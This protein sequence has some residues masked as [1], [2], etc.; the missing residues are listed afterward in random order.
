MNA[1]LPGGTVT[2]LFTDIEGSTR[3]WEKNPEVMQAAMRRHDLL[4]R[5]VVVANHGQIVKMTGD[6][7]HA[8][9]ASAADGLAA[10][11][12]G[13][14]ALQA[15]IWPSGGALHV[16]MALHSGEAELRAGD[17]FGT[18]PNRAARLMAA[19]TGGQIL[20]SQSTADLIQDSLPAEV[21]LRDLGEHQL[22]D[23]VRLEHIFQVVALDLPV[24]FPPLKT[25]SVLPHNLPVQLTSFVG[26]EQEIVE[27]R[28]LL[29]A[30][31]LLTLTGPGGT[32]KT[33]L[34]LQI[35]AEV[36]PDYPDG[37]WLVELAPLADPAYI[38][39]AL[40]AVFDLREQPNRPL[41]AVVTDY[42]RGKA[43]LLLFD[44]C[45]HL[46]EACARLADELLHACPR[47]RIIASSREVLGVA[48]ETVYRV[49]ALAL[50]D[51]RQETPER[52]QQSE[53]ARLFVERAQSAQPHFTLTPSN[54]PAVAAICQRLDGIPLAL[55]LAASRV[56]L[57][58]VE[59]IAVRLDDRFRLLVG[60]S[61]TA[62]PRQQ[63]LRA[64]MDWSYDLL[65]EE[66]RLL[67]RQLAV[68]AGGWGMEAAEA[69][70][71]CPDALGVMEQLV[72][73]SLVSV[74]EQGG[75]ARY[76]LLETIR[77]YA[78]D[79]LLEAGEAEEAR[80]RH[81]DYYLVLSEAAE[82]KL[83]GPEMIATLDQLEAE[84]DNLRAALEWASEKDPL[85]AL[86]L[87]AVLLN[88]WRLRV[89]ATEGL[90][91]VRTA[92]ARAEAA[93]EWEGE[94]AQ[95]Y[96][97]ARAKALGGEANLAFV[98]GHNLEARTA[99]EASV[100]LARQI[101][102][103]RTL[104]QALGMGGIIVGMVG[105]T[106]K[107]RAW[108]EESIAL[109]LQHGYVNEL[110]MIS[111]AHMF[112]ALIT[113]Q[114]VPPGLREKALQ[115]ARTTGNPWVL[116]MVISNIGRVE[117]A[118]GNLA[119]AHA[120]FE[121]A[122]ALFQQIRDRAMYNSTRSEIGHVFR[123][124]GRYPEAIAVYRHTILVW[125]DLGSQAA[126]AH[127]LE[128]FAF[129]A[130]A[131]GQNERSARLLGAAEDLRES[132]SSSMVPMERPEYD[133]F[134]AGLH[135]VMEAEMLKSAWEQGRLL[136]MEAAIQL[137]LEGEGVK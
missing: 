63:T 29:A 79:K 120:R 58:S 84:Q 97:A 94:A 14:R 7:L 91:W 132:I 71:T 88:F 50:P 16:R 20:I 47:L 115:V 118:S 10:V 93:Q 109:C 133:T 39:P 18:A 37:V 51:D 54:A 80:D 111:G 12:A 9:F 81:L 134:V 92:L 67:L 41:Q 96:L 117:T 113:N 103:T 135:R 112:L 53:A 46:I 33:R 102:A 127:Q 52:L 23:L 121:E 72:N 42:L 48:G 119:E 76:R 25:L 60:G 26:R 105:D 21:S 129:I 32:G 69:V 128:C 57:L 64:L 55:E 6:G 104:A 4:L 65:P 82:P 45:E 99:M 101:G 68:F 125:Q 114:P 31:H 1:D 137:A 66:E 62:L 130:G 89:S 8:V 24:D 44:N 136:S 36:L 5:E 123:K 90:T 28:R 74:T 35:A 116:A 107:A 106:A 73:K 59:Q 86:R 110:G 15:E 83:L 70:G 98:L 22:K 27:A 34:A 78:R 124:Q 13:Q 75:E 19:G 40:A 11:L 95:T 3:L 108:V 77:Q 2:F 49:P 85:S 87:A 100:S 38:L 30:S 61:R 43:L 56:K 17:Y 122:A 126:I 131:K